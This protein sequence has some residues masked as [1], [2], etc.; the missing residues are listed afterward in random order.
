MCSQL[1]QIHPRES[2]D[3]HCLLGGVT[4]TLLC[5]GGAACTHDLDRFGSNLLFPGSLGSG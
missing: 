3:W 1:L 4:A 5:T 2:I